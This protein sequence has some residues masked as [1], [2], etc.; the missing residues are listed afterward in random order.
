MNIKKE[1]STIEFLNKDPYVTQLAID[2]FTSEFSNKELHDE[3][4][5]TL[6]QRY[7]KKEPINSSFLRGLGY[8]LEDFNYFGSTRKEYNAKGFPVGI[9]P[10]IIDLLL[11]EN[12]I[13]NTTRAF[14]A[15]GEVRY[16]TNH[17]L[18]SYLRE[19]NLLD[20]L[21]F[22][23]QYIIEKYRNSTF[24]IEIGYKNGDKAG[25]TGFL[26]NHSGNNIII[27]NR[28]VIENA[29]VIKAFSKETEIEI[30]KIAKSRKSDL[31]FIY[32]PDLNLPHFFLNPEIKILEEIITIGFPYIPGTKLQFQVVHR[33]EINSIVE[34]YEGNSL[35]LFSAKTSSGN[36]GS[37][38]IDKYG[39][40]VGIITK[41]LFEKKSFTEMGKP[42]YYAAINSSTIIEELDI[43][44]KKPPHS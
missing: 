8:S 42:P 9:G 38:V 5:I 28:H 29:E 26:I 27:T 32:I 3:I 19:N 12:L 2:F 31:A 36:S 24:L 25:G 4:K 7:S 17:E 10:I 11:K 43:I 39:S 37:P 14:G 16:R 34:D 30:L 40:I 35:F 15:E 41:E 44:E 22:G 21:I 20:N 33:G 1:N 23:I 18:T 13:R 6:Q